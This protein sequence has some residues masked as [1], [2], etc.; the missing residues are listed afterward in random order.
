MID[1]KKLEREIDDLLESETEESILNWYM[2]KKFPT[3]KTQLGEGEFHTLSIP[4]LYSKVIQTHLIDLIDH[5]YETVVDSNCVQY[6][7]AA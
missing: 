1:L 2:S 4:D 7:M 6:S 5:E 3:Y